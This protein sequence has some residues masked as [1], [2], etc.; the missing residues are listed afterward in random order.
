[1]SNA[2]VRGTRRHAAARDTVVAPE[3]ATRIVAANRGGANIAV[4]AHDWHLS[5]SE[6]KALLRLQSRDAASG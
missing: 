3:V 6:T 1:V 4:L 5:L 2:R